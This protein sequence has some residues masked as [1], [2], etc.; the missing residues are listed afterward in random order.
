LIPAIEVGPRTW[1]AVKNWTV[2]TVIVIQ[3][4]FSSIGRRT[5]MMKRTF[6]VKHPVRATM[7]GNKDHTRTFRPGEMVS[8]DV[9]QSS[10]LV[11]FEVDFVQF[12]AARI[13]FA[14]SV[15]TPTP[16]KLSAGCSQ[17]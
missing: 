14:K 10:D 17:P 15:E 11:N 16:G 13:E 2:L 7:I 12:E 8:C 1:A 4:L 9:D 5:A 6:I 3:F